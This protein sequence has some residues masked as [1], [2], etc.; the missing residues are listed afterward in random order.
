MKTHQTKLAAAALITF[1]ATAFG[2]ANF[3][4]PSYDMS[5]F[6]IDGGGG[7][8]TGGS[9]SLS[10]TIGQHDA[11][12]PLTGGSYSLSGGFWAGA[13]PS[14]SLATLL[15]ISTSFGTELGGDLASLA[16]SDNNYYRAR[17][18]FGF[19]SSEPNLCRI[20]LAAQSDN[21]AATSF[22][23]LIEGR[24]NNPDGAV[25]VRARNYDG[26]G[27]LQTIA[28]YT[29]QTTDTT[30]II[31]D[32]PGDFIRNSDGRM[33]FQIKQ[34]V[35]ATFSLSGFISFTDQIEITTE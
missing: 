6:T 13:G 16:N 2:M 1:A 10:G 8:S 5:W 3:G 27:S 14:E 28:T 22:D 12:G 18:A 11:G 30:V 19:L 26:S 35:I 31:E 15:S 20:E 21:P 32:N 23:M 9:Y 25:T 29:A 4:G 24:L 7:T 33:E 34:V 17:S